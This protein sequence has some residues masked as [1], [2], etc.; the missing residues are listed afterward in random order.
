MKAKATRSIDCHMHTQSSTGVYFVL[1]FFKFHFFKLRSL[2]SATYVSSNRSRRRNG[3]PSST[4]LHTFQMWREIGKI[5]VF[6]SGTSC[7]DAYLVFPWKAADTHRALS[8]NPR[9]HQHDNVN[10]RLAHYRQSREK[11]RISF[12][13]R[14]R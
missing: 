4:N 2:A 9:V 14:L 13:C 3:Q 1:S 8:Q 10:V 11:G 5:K 7:M 6:W 12:F